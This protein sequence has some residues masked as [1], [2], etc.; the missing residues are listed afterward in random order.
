MLLIG[1]NPQINFRNLKILYHRKSIY[2]FL[3]INFSQSLNIN[4]C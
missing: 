3:E 1:I 2:N 4:L